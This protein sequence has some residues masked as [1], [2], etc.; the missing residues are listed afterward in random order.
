[1]TD[2]FEYAARY[3]QAPGYKENATSRIAAEEIAGD[4]AA[5]RAR[6]LV[7]LQRAPSTVHEMAARL[8]RSI[9]AVAPRFSE[10][11]KL[12]QIVA[13]GERR[14]NPTSGKSAHVWKASRLE[15]NHG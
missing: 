2:L 8:D 12:G 6:V 4:A 9:F 10:L 5:L 1:M 3:P 13:S 7:E 14:V 15:G 11:R